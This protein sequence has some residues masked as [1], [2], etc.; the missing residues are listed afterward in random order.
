MNEVKNHVGC[1]SKSIKKQIRTS[2]ISDSIVL[3]RKLKNSRHW[4]G[5]R[6]EGT[7]KPLTISHQMDE[8]EIQV[9]CLSES[10]KETDQVLIFRSE[11]Q[12]K[13]VFLQFW[14]AN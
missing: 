5:Y 3:A 8:H 1:L 11:P 7:K 13:L 10:I 2:K 9:Q 6:R 14:L 12:K 4:Q